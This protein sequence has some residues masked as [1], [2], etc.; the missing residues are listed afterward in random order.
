MKWVV[1]ALAVAFYFYEFLLRI[2]P[3]VMLP[4]LMSAFKVDAAQLGALSAFYLFAYAPLQIP[5]G[6]MMDRW[7]ARRLETIACI[8][9]GLGGIL[10]GIAPVLGVADIGRVL[11]GIGSA[12]AFVGMVYVCGHWFKRKQLPFLIGL[13]T[14]IGMIGAIA[15]EIPV[16][17]STEVFGW[18]VTSYGF[19]ILGIVLAFVIFL[20][21]RNAPKG[22]LPGGSRVDSFGHLWGNLKGVCKN[23]QTWLVGIISLSIY[24]TTTAFAGLW[25]PT[26]LQTTYGF[27]KDLAS[28]FTAAIFIGWIFGA[29]LVSFLAMHTGH[30]RPFLIIG[31]LVAGVAM[32]AIVYIPGLNHTLLFILLLFVGLFSSAQVLTFSLAIELNHHS[33]K[34]TA[35]ALIN[36]LVMLAGSLF[37]PL[38]GYFLD[39]SAGKANGIAAYTAGDFRFALTL[40]P[41]SF[42][43][44]CVLSFFISHRR[45]RVPESEI[46]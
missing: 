11:M 29:P 32:T 35:A 18:R 36:F 15:G 6:L 25:G 7:G 21:M 23:F 45:R 13:G 39:L 46:L 38:V 42:F 37:Q 33:A 22:G 3:S 28:T 19:G 14:S 10:F 43:V 31:A 30:R 9:C 44:G 34:G 4:E 12:F 5:V 2:S 16:A 41:I 17:V 24:A 8:L 20:A 27:D 40:F 26:F 1:W